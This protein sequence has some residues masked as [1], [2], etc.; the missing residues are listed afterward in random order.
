MIETTIES[1]QIFKGRL[2]SVRVDSVRLPDGRVSVREV[3]EHP[4]AIAVVPVDE[5]GNVVLVQQFR[6]AIGD[7]LLEIPAGT[8][9]AGESPEDCARRELQEEIGCSPGSLEKLFEVYLA[10][11]YSTELIHY[12]LATD[13]TASVAAHDHDE[14]IEVHRIPLLEALEMIDAGRIRDAKTVAGIA[15]AARRLPHL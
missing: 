7:L 3:V 9:E 14:F 11:G 1:K 15:L 12:F 5:D 8:L 2:I 13:L 6:Y 10:P 4:G